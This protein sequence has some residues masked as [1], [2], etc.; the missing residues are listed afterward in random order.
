MIILG[1]QALCQASGE[2]RWHWLVERDE[3]VAR[4]GLKPVRR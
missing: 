2:S 3:L 1:N 4:M